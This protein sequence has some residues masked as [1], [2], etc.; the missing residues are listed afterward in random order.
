MYCFSS[1]QKKH[2][3]PDNIAE[4]PQTV[5]KC[6]IIKRQAMH[7]ER[8]STHSPR[9]RSPTRTHP[10]RRNGSA[11]GPLRFWNVFTHA[12][13]WS[14]NYTYYLS[15]YRLHTRSI[16]TRE[17]WS[18]RWRSL[19]NSLLYK[20]RQ[21]SPLFR[22]LLV[23]T[24]SSESLYTRWWLTRLLVGYSTMKTTVMKTNSAFPSRVFMR[25]LRVGL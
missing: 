19:I 5:Y 13:I 6:S 4:R 17:S 23:I 16:N 24:Y 14:I 25:S 2:L 1:T 8:Y 12:W 10:P 7:H 3:S 15:T 21:R 18:S 9:N 22:R 20:K 11:S